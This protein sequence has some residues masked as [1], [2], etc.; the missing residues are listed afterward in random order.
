[1]KYS[2][3]CSKPIAKA[4]HCTLVIREMLYLSTPIGRQLLVRTVWQID[5]GTDFPRLITLIP[6]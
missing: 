1:M 2:N 6:D 4:L 3:R 5:Q